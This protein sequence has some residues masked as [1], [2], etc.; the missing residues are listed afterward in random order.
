MPSNARPPPLPSRCPSLPDGTPR[1]VK[2]A[3]IQLQ[4]EGEAPLDLEKGERVFLVEEAGGLATV[5]LL[6]GTQGTVPAKSLK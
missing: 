3:K 1:V 5:T 4:R 2:K 6:D